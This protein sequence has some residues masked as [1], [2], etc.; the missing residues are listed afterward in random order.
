MT[1]PMWTLTTVSWGFP[2]L[3]HIPVWSLDWRQ[4]ACHEC[5]PDIIY[6]SSRS[7]RATCMGNR[8]RTVLRRLLFAA[9]THWAPMRDGVFQWTV[10]Q[11]E[12][13]SP[14]TSTRLHMVFPTFRS[15]RTGRL[16]SCWW[17]WSKPLP[18]LGPLLQ[19]LP[20]RPR[21]SPD[22]STSLLSLPSDVC[23]GKVRTSLTTF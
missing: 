3:P 14:V 23:S 1:C 22:K 16:A 18:S 4:H 12:R 9:V 19:M 15:N 11:R 2:K 10:T 7:L 21:S 20:L 13:M 5:P 8:L 6:L 17:S